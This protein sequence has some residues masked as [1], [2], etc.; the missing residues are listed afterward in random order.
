VTFATLFPALEP[1]IRALGQNPTALAIKPFIPHF[2]VAHLVSL[3]VLGGCAILLNLR[4]IGVGF[5]EPSSWVARRIRPMLDLG[6]AGVLAT[7]VLIT[8]L[9]PEKIYVDAPFVVKML[10]LLGA[11]VGTYGAALPLAKADGVL[12]RSALSALVVSL[13]LWGLALGIFANAVDARA[14]MILVIFG[15]GLLLAFAL[16]GRIRW[17][18]LIGLT[19][20]LLAQQVVTI[21][22]IDPYDVAVLDPVNTAFS[23]AEAAWVLAFL[24]VLGGARG[25]ETRPASRLVGCAT[26]LMWVTVGAAGRWIAFG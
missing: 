22:F 14:G 26:L 9:E 2:L 12:S 8:A 3:F 23:C 20:I 10:A 24:L 5:E 11:L 15:G 6:V 18:Y 13:I 16:A 4:L 17:V 19:V 21:G 25:L 1:S 7:G